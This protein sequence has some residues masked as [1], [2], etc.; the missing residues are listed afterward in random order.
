MFE[1]PSWEHRVCIVVGPSPT[2]IY[3]QRHIDVG[4]RKYSPAVSLSLFFL[5]LSFY[6]FLPESFLVGVDFF[7]SIFFFAGTALTCTPR[8]R[9]VRYST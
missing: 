9:H 4:R 5:S 3:T 6:F 1:G 2:P 7:F 8:P